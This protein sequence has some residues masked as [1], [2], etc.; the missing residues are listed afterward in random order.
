MATSTFHGSKTVIF[1]FRN[2]KTL[3]DLFLLT[4]SYDLFPLIKATKLVAC[5]VSV[6]I[7]CESDL[8]F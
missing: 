4:K 6:T 7:C 1:F 5:H 2:Q 3:V 8:L